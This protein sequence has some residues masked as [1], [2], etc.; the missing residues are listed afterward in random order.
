MKTY[1]VVTGIVKFKDKILILKKSKDDWNYPNKWSLC[2]GYVKEFESA[3][4]T[5]L[6]EIKEETG[7]NAKII[8]KGKL[9]EVRDN[10]KGKIWVI[11]T[12][13]CSVKS[14]KIKLCN[15]NQEFRWIACK[16]LSKYDTVPG[17]KKD[18]KVLGLV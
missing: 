2:S 5:V 11:A 9:I 13:L 8:K 3:E 16:D 15:E 10:K 17:L 4:D 12:F 18:L 7:L 14:Q 6:R 1:F